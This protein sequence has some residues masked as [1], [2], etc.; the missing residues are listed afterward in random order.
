MDICILGE[1]VISVFM[2]PKAKKQL[3]LLG[4]TRILIFKSSKT[5]F[6]GKLWQQ[7]S[8]CLKRKS[9]CIS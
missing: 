2:L 7:C 8:C 1:T 4:G 3:H 5:V 6:W 9:N